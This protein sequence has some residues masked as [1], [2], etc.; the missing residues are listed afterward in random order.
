MLWDF[1]GVILDSPFDGFARYE[2]DHGLPAGFLRTVNAANPDDNA[3]AR[4]E[5]GE[6]DAAE[7]TALEARPGVGVGVGGDDAAEEP[8]GQPVLLFVA[9]ETVKRALQDDPSEVPEHP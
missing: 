2:E 5:R 9:R 3:W 4:L 1:G 7:F 8:G 6:L